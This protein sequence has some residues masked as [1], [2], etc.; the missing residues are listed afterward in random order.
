M[1]RTLFNG[2]KLISWTPDNEFVEM[3]LRDFCTWS[4]HDMDFD[5]CPNSSSIL[6]F[7]KLNIF[8]KS[9]C[10]KSVNIRSPGAPKGTLKRTLSLIRVPPFFSSNSENCW[11]PLYIS[12]CTVWMGCAPAI[13][14]F[15]GE[16]TKDPGPTGVAG[17]EVAVRIL[18]PAST[19]VL[20]D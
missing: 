7:L 5:D 1:N 11:R 17:A 3:S 12:L 20:S 18:A 10:I 14:G 15:S 8:F 2:C 6:F 16:T 13:P 9:F 19:S 4:S